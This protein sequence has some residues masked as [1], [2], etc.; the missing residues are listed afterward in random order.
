[1]LHEFIHWQY[2][3]KDVTGYN[4]VVKL[5]PVGVIDDYNYNAWR[6]WQPEVYWPDP[7]E[8]GYGP[9]NAL[10]LN[11]NYNDIAH[12]GQVNADNYRWYVQS[13]WWSLQCGRNFDKAPADG[14]KT[15]DRLRNWLPE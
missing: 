11:H 8:N 3:L 13:K 12:L 7:P 1:M 15:D 4:D 9:F 6:K 14:G 2:L 10:V 5:S